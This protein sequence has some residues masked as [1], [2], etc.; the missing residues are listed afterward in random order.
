MI[1]FAQ[2]ALAIIVPAKNEAGS[3]QQLVN[4]IDL[5]MK[6]AGFL[7]EVLIVDDYSTDKTFEIAQQLAKKYPLRVFKKKGKP[8]KAYAILEGVAQTTAPYVAFIDADLQYPPEAL[9]EMLPLTEQAGLVI[10]RRRHAHKSK[11]RTFFSKVGKFV[12]GKLLFGFTYDVQSGLKVF[13]RE[14]ISHLSADDVSPWTIDLPLVVTADRLGYTIAEV[15]IDFS[16]R[17]SGESKINLVRTVK[18]ILHRALKYKFSPETPLSIHPKNGEVVGSGLVY[19]KNRYITHTRLSHRNSAIHTI[20][21]W[22]KLIALGFVS[23]CISTV[24]FHSVELAIGI[25]GFLST[26]YFIDV[27]FNFVLVMRSLQFSPEITT[28][29]EEL[30]AFKD[31]DLPIYSILCP[32]YKEAHMVPGFVEAIQNLEWPK[33]KLDVMLLL[34]EDD[35][36]TVAAAREMNLPSYVRIVVVPDSLPKTKPKACNYGLLLAKGEYLVIFDAE[37]NPDPLQLKKVFAAFKKVPSDIKCIQAKL[38]YYN[39]SQ[40]LLT[41][42]FTAE[43]SLWFDVILTG[44]QS[45]STTI[46]LGGTSNHFKTQDLIDLQ[47]WDAFNVTEDCDLGV[48]LFKKGGRTAIV[49][50]VTLE[51]ANSNLGNWIRQ[52]S[53]W[54]KGYMQ[55][56][57]LHM[58]NPIEL[59]KAYGWHALIFQLTIGGK[60]AFLLINP[61][62]WILTISYFVL[63]AYVGP[64]IEKLF[65]S[66]IFYMAASSLIFGNFL[67]IYYYMIGLAK[68]EQWS[69]LKYVFLVPFYWLAA[70]YAAGI[71]LYQLIVKPHYWEKTV[72]GLHLKAKEIEQQAESV[73]TTVVAEVVAESMV[74][75]DPNTTTQVGVRFPNISI[76]SSLK[77]K[78]SSLPFQKQLK[79][80][81]AKKYRGGIFVV[82]AS[83]AANFLNMATNFYLGEE[84][85]VSEFALITTYMSLLYLFSVPVSAFSATINHAT[86]QLLGKHNKNSFYSFWAHLKGRMALFAIFIASIWIIFVPTVSRFL[87]NTDQI[88]LLSF[89]IVIIAGLIGAVNEGYL[90]GKLYFAA[91]AAVI[92]IEPVVRLAAAI[93]FGESRLQPY[94]YLVVPIG[95]LVTAVT[96]KVFAQKESEV[97]KIPHK[98]FRLSLGFFLIALITRLST[99]AFF[100]IDTLLLAHYFSAKELGTYGLLSL[101]GKMIFFAGT[102]ISAFMLPLV[103]NR[104]GKGKDSRDILYKILLLTTVFSCLAYLVVGIGV[105]LIS[106]YFFGSKLTTIAQFLPFYGIGILC[107]TIGQTLV[108]YHLA[109]KQYFFAVTSFIFSIVEAV[110]LY[111]FHSSIDQAVIVVMIT[112]II[113]LTVLFIE[114]IIFTTFEET[115]SNIFELFHNKRISEQPKKNNPL[116]SNSTLSIVV[117]NWR[118]PKHKWAGGAEEFIFNISAEL[119]KMGHQVTLFCANDGRLPRHEISQGVHVIRRG[120]FVTVYIWAFLYYVLKLRKECDVVLDCENGIPFLSP[121]YVKKPINLL[122]HH[123]HQEVFQQHLTFPLSEIAGVIE[124]DLMPVL[125]K[126]VSLMTVSNSSKKDIVGLG[127]SD[128]Q[129]TII[130]PGISDLLHQKIQVKKSASPSFCYV[131]RLQSYKNVDILVS[132]FAKILPVLPEAKLVIAGTGTNEKKIKRQVERMGLQEF[133]TFAGRVSEDDKRRILAESWIAVQPSSIEGWGIT[134]IEAMACGTPVIASNVAGLKDSVV[135]GVTGLLVPVKSVAMLSEKMLLLAN[136]HKLRTTLRNNAKKYASQFTWTKAAEKC[137]ETIKASLS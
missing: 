41:R 72:H 80:L 11:T 55:T 126:R 91:M 78:L 50:S 113:S 70:S 40:N 94:I 93:V 121:L 31:E 12:T 95:V 61:L 58:R 47:G 123:V 33:E 62:M 68:R 67:F 29:P 110:G 92:V 118:D 128:N 30:A 84:L 9:I 53:R 63:Y 85:S 36:K 133:V 15:D 137:I 22:Q 8:G 46:P 119:V 76:V 32:L 48:R 42:F 56:Y 81:I 86:A 35:V 115:F 112:G 100:S 120:N 74:E 44:L 111:F 52:R 54:I 38:N 89:A 108:Q 51:E 73:V 82:I 5:A 60:I 75:S 104:E 2:Q 4:R 109:K 114:H 134:V 79:F 98:D 13:K 129:V 49:D 20:S 57:L 3:L 28:T 96:S 131:G 18:E 39:A 43:Y 66:V 64:A 71:A 106:P 130:E 124:G 83:F 65:P 107:F 122:V 23:L 10:A 99:I 97:E 116:S 87:N 17:E 90:K 69:L 102:T 24:F 27:L 7:Y 125:Y 19:K 6:K 1:L 103:A 34:E 117:F 16:K 21:W 26:V 88:A 25:V 77:N 101:F 135:D 105:P 132:A 136:D 59:T 127:F 45:F 14:I 37:D